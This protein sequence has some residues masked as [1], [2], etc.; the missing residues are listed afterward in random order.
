MV[1]KPNKGTITS[2]LDYEEDHKKPKFDFF[3]HRKVL[4]SLALI[5]ILRRTI[6]YIFRKDG[7]RNG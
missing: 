5:P 7:N 1:K 3:R 4:T 6:K 2:K